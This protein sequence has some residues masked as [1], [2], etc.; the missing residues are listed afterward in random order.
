[1]G[2]PYIYIYIYIYI[3]D[4][5]RLR[6][7]STPHCALYTTI[8]TPLLACVAFCKFFYCRGGV[9]E[10]F[11]LFDVTSCLIPAEQRLMHRCLFVN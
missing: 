10:V 1:M 11:I 2:A 8:A 6:V 9:E 5:S 7:N 3:Y 4:I